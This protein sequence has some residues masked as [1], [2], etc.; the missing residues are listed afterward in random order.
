MSTRRTS[1]EMVESL[2]DASRR[3]LSL[4][5]HRVAEHPTWAG[6][7]GWKVFLDHPDEIRRT[8]GYIEKN[9]LSA[10]LPP[11]HWG[12]VVRYDGWPLHP[13]HS[14]NSPYTRRLREAGMYPGVGR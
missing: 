5:G 13:G 2:K 14:P 4:T 8:I 11:Q 9:P 7:D 1:A 3:R 10:R 6:G 12:F